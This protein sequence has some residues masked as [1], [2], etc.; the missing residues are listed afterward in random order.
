[1]PVL[2]R[3]EIGL[4]NDD[5]VF[6]NV[7]SLVPAKAHLLILSA[8][9]EVIAPHPEAK[10]LCIG[11][12]LDQEYGKFVKAQIAAYSL[13]KHIRLV[14]DGGHGLWAAPHSHEGGRSV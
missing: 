11:D 2:R 7:A 12:L 8:L 9:K 14:D 4:G 13:E 3:E 10:V 1:L 5:Y 6:L